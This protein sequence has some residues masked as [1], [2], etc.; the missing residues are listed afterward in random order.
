MK[1]KIA[2]F[3]ATWFYSGLL[4]SFIPG[5]MAG[6][7]A[8]LLSIPLCCFALFLA[9]VFN[10]FVYLAVALAVLL[11]GLWS[12]PRAEAVLGP[13]I[14]WRGEIKKHDQNQIV[15]DEVLGMLVSCFPVALF[16]PQSLFRA[17]ALAFLLFRFFDT[18]KI[19]PINL[20]DRME[21]AAGVM[22]DDLLAGI[23]A[24]LFLSLLILTAGI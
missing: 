19:P 12:I 2:L 14:D 20:F 5:A 7:Y 24:A 11:L 10:I 22:L 16:G 4:P 3:L 13:R 17:F 18:A 1:D 6:I 21:N 8:S 9:E 23:Y 15:I